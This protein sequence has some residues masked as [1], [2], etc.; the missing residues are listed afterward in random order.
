MSAT[1]HPVLTIGHSNHSPDAFMALLRLH[2]VREVIDVRTSP[3]S[4]YAPHFNHAPLAAMLESA[5]IMEYAF[6]GGEL[7]GRPGDRSCYDSDGR[8]VYDRLAET[9]L[10]LDGISYVISTPSPDDWEPSH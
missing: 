5:G 6:R 10:F 4:R 8:V 9:D 2:G 1:Q 3:S 7:G